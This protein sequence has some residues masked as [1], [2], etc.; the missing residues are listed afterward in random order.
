M[1]LIN[2]GSSSPGIRSLFEFR[3]ETGAPLKR[4]A[5]RLLHGES[6][7]SKGEREL[8]AAYTSHGNQ[9][10]FCTM[11]HAAAARHHYGADAAIVDAVVYQRDTSG[12]SQKMQ[13]L[14]AIAEKVRIGGRIVT[15]DDVQ[16]ARA[17]GA[18]DRDIHDT[19]IIT[20]AFCM[21]NRYVDGLRA[22]T[23]TDPEAYVPM[24]ARMAE[25][26]YDL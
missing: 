3:P 11:S 18:G 20:A 25:Q 19:V 1:A 15:D 2:T 22:L 13:R 24:G 21:Y 14:L 12:L 4:L 17:A 26:G 9:C 6:P 10:V 5:H 16:A 7:L 23:P 8:I